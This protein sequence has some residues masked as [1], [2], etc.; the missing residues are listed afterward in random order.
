M[1][2]EKAEKIIAVGALG[3]SGTRAVAQILIESG[4]Y[5]GDNLNESND[6]LV[7]TTL[8]KNVEWYIGASEADVMRRMLILA[9]YMR[10]ERFSI[11]DFREFVRATRT[12]PFLDGGFRLYFRLLRKLLPSPKRARPSVW[13]WKEPNSQMFVDHIKTFFPKIRYI[14]VIRNGLDMAFSKNLQ[15][16]KNWGYLYD[17]H[18]DGK[19][20]ETELA[21]KQLEFW[22]KSSEKV[23]IE[24]K[25]LFN[26]NFYLLNHT[27]FCTNPVVE[28]EELLEFL[29]LDVP[30]NIRESLFKIPV[31][32]ASFERY[33]NYD[34][35]TFSEDQIRLVKS[36][37]FDI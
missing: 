24:G 36:F 25:K 27:K 1:E 31:V 30:K 32:P 37:G 7:F 15:Q 29:N 28:V 23:I 20:T 2:L 4:V 17:I 8:F 19:E 11:A 3:G 33:K 6:N 5:L 10:R 26:E 9:K 35:N 34:I 22:I 12:N 16:L 18:V 21:V 13:G 14:H